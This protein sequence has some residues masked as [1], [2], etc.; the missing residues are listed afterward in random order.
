MKLYIVWDITA[1][2]WYVSIPSKLRWQSSTELEYFW[3]MEGR[4]LK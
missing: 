3:L 4:L 2:N 1:R